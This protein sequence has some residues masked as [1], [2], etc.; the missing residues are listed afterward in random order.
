MH[1]FGARW[2]SFAAVNFGNRRMVFFCVRLFRRCF[3]RASFSTLFF[4]WRLVSSALF[5][6]VLRLFV[7][8]AGCF[9][10]VIGLLRTLSATSYY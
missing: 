8:A 5:V 4:F 3:L 9:F 6:I 1:F 10:E 7:F 2:S